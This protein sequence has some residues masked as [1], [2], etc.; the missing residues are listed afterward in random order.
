MMLR[1]PDNSF[2]NEN[3]S[4]HDEEGG[5]LLNES[6]G[7]LFK[8][9]DDSSNTHEVSIK[10]A[11]LNHLYSTGINYITPVVDKIVEN[12]PQNHG[13]NLSEDDYRELV[14]NIATVSWV[15]QSSGKKHQRCN[16]SFASKYVHFLS[17]RR[18]PIYD[19][20][21]WILISGYIYQNGEKQISF[22]PPVNYVNFYS[23]FLQFK[24]SYSLGHFSNYDLDKFLWQYGKNLISAIIKEE[25]ISLAKARTKLKKRITK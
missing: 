2:I 21:I 11:A 20:Y 8:V 5:N 23:R 9:F 24:S 6:L 14:D 13:D 16:L 3:L 17:N 18:I 7:K 4:I 19:S 1:I 10:V 12:I 25:N 22:S 15:S